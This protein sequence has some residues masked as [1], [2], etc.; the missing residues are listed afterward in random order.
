MYPNVADY[1]A[2]ARRR[3][4]RI[5]FDYLDGGAEDGRALQ[6]NLDAYGRILLSPRVLRDLSSCST[7]A[8]WFGRRHAAPMV[9]G[10]TGLNGLFWP[11]ADEALAGAAAAAGLPFALSSAS[12]SLLEDV[13]TA[14]PDGDLWLQLYVQSERRIA[15]DMMRRAQEA[16]FSTLLLTVDTPVHGKR[17][18]DM[19]NGFKL[20]LRASPAL[21]WDLVRNPH[22][23]LQMA[24]HGG[25]QLRNI[26]RSLGEAPNLESQAAALSRQ[27]DLTLNWSDM[28]WLRRHWR[29]P[30]IVKGIQAV[31][32]A[33][34][35]VEHGVDGIV[36]SNHGGRQLESACAPLD[37]LPAVADAVGHKLKVFVDGG[38]R[39]GADVVKAVALGACGVLLGRA[40]LYGLAAR[41]GP[42]AREVLALLTDEMLITLRLLGCNSLEDLGAHTIAAPSASVPD[43]PA[44]LGQRSSAAA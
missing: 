20:P 25:P 21:L 44:A 11:R 31:D 27:M 40:P 29:G 34:L 24:R 36:L 38:V 32:D 16:G 41:G 2:A 26:A 13:R 1:R 7:Q 10:P 43:N 14:V 9:I 18:H 23:S 33:R 35:A 4:P 12:T 30:V 3:L 19:R 28:A 5:A 6:R 8:E 17:D 39:R 37:V 42:G 22:W 15:E